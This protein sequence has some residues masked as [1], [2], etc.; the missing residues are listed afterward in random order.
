MQYINENRKVLHWIERSQ[1][2]T[3]ID[4]LNKQI[5]HNK[6]IGEDLLLLYD[7]YLEDGD[8]DSAIETLERAHIYIRFID[9][10]S[11]LRIA[12]HLGD[13][14]FKKGEYK[15]A[16]IKYREAYGLNRKDEEL[17]LKLGLLYLE[18]RQFEAA[19]KIFIYLV[20]KHKDSE[21]YQTFLGHYFCENG[22]YDKGEAIL[23]ELVAKDRCNYG[24]IYYLGRCY[25]SLKD[26][27]AAL[28]QF[29]K[30][31]NEREFR[32]EAAYYMGMIYFK[33]LAYNSASEHFARAVKLIEVENRETLEMRYN[34][35]ICYEHSKSY[36]KA[37][38]ELRAI[39]S[40]NPNYKDIA[41]KLIS[42]NYNSLSQ[43]YLLDYNSY[44]RADFDKFV[45]KLL[46]NFNLK[47]I[48]QR[49]GGEDTTFIYD[50][51]VDR[52]GEKFKFFG[53]M[54]NY[55]KKEAVLVIFCRTIL[56]R[57]DNIRQILE[58]TGEKYKKGI[59]LS[60]NKVSI[61]AQKFAGKKRINTVIPTFLNSL[62][63]QYG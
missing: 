23:K 51:E 41:E 19:G 49:N 62:I 1:Q 44:S 11:R 60:S 17:Y 36:N 40:V 39:Y 8:Y 15:R 38:E 7:I 50:C 31:V 55:Q 5:E 45:R 54:I 63:K 24:A 20:K 59:L 58:Q 43:N 52:V 42:D 30:L 14:Y 32:F 22:E 61:L 26:H 57:E 35:A 16:F 4:Y 2:S 29:E 25:Y 34:L 56:I 21:Y 18:A 12:T 53:N 46:S 47:V 9:E 37:L 28:R 10:K 3:A 33:G 6:R 13:L 27:K 48:G